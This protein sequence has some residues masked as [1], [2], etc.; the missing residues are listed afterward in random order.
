MKVRSSE[1]CYC[2]HRNTNNIW[3]ENRKRTHNCNM[4]SSVVIFIPAFCGHLLETHNMVPGSFLNKLGEKNGCHFF[5]FFLLLFKSGCVNL[6]FITV[7]LFHFYCKILLKKGCIVYLIITWSLATLKFYIFS[8]KNNLVKGQHGYTKSDGHYFFRLSEKE[9][10]SSVF[11]NDRQW[12]QR[13]ETHFFKK[14]QQ[15]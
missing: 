1:L 15:F 3:K 11:T 4:Q 2:V 7:F 5:Q 6:Q 13:Y 10:R 14:T 9:P 8:P 12:W